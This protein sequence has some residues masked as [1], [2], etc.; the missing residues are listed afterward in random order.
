MKKEVLMCLA[1]ATVAAV[2]AEVRTAGP[3]EQTAIS[4][5]EGQSVTETGPI[6]HDSLASGFAK[7]GTGDYTLPLGTVVQTTPLELSVH[8]GKVKLVDNGTAATVTA[9]D[10]MQ[11][12]VMWL[13]ANDLANGSVETWLDHREATSDQNKYLCVRQTAA[14]NQPTAGTDETGKKW[15]N[16]D[17]YG[18][19]KF[20]SFYNTA[21]T[22]TSK[23]ETMHAFSV[24]KFVASYG[25]LWG[26]NSTYDVTFHGSG[27][28]GGNYWNATE[29]SAAVVEGRTFVNGR[30]I[31]GGNEK[32]VAGVQLIEWAAG[33]RPAQILNFFNDRSIQG[34]QGGGYVGEAVFF[35]KS[36]SESERQQVE[37]YLMQKWM[38]P[39]CPSVVNVRTAEGSAVELG[40]GADAVRVTGVGTVTKSSDGTLH[41]ADAIQGTSAVSWNLAA[42]NLELEQGTTRLALQSGAALASSKDAYGVTTLA[43]EVGVAAGSASVTGGSGSFRLETLPG[44]VS[45]V[46]LT[47]GSLTLGALEDPSDGSEAPKTSAAVLATMSNPGFESLTKINGQTSTDFSDG[48]WT[49]KKANGN[50]AWFFMKQGEGYWSAYTP[51]TPV[52]EG[53][54]CVGFNF[55][56]QTI[57]ETATAATQVEFPQDGDY[58]LSFR[59]VSRPPA[60]G[61]YSNFETYAWSQIEMTLTDVNQDV[62]DLCRF[63]SEGAYLKTSYRSD[64]YLIRGIKAGTYTFTVK[65]THKRTGEKLTLLDDFKFQLV[66]PVTAE[67]VFQVPN[68][69]FERHDYPTLN[70]FD[71]SVTAE[72]WTFTN[73]ELEAG[74]MAA[75]GPLRNGIYTSNGQTTSYAQYMESVWFVS[76]GS[77]YGQC[78]LAFFGKDGKAASAAFVPPAGKWRLR[79]RAACLRSKAPNWN[80]TVVNAAGRVSAKVSVNGGTPVDLG[81]LDISHNDFLVCT[82]PMSFACSGSEPVNIELTQLTDN[83][84]ARL[85]DLELVRDDELITNGNFGTGVGSKTGWTTDS[86]TQMPNFTTDGNYYYGKTV[87]DGPALIITKQGSAE[88]EIEFSE[89]GVYRL[90]FWA[91]GRAHYASPTAEL[92]VMNFAQNRLRFYLKKGGDETEIYRTEK[93]NSTNFVHYTALFPVTTA[94]TYTFGFQGTDT[95]DHSAWIDLVSVKKVSA[96]A[97]PEIPAETDL[98]IRLADGEKLRLDY[99]GSTTV[100]GLKVNGHRLHG[101]VS[102]ATCPDYVTG[103]GSLTATYRPGL[104]LI[105]Q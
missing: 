31:D 84:N 94:G 51:W 4:V 99:T 56:S 61:D 25:F 9:P 1:A 13:D 90:S 98:D 78:Q 58:M 46:V 5:A 37:M 81:Y 48:G 26:V 103:P 29:G 55:N 24:V 14:A 82:F 33:E 59:D 95:E 92:P 57:G 40:D 8:Q 70:A 6:R 66:E 88:Q 30:Q 87:I 76:A 35:D 65:F 18:S 89:T 27:V 34:R 52:P 85:D 43:K 42:G 32:V 68:G 53:S 101:E 28:I 80:G 93:L 96:A 12:A 105:V 102:A 64:R 16:F 50:S 71:T 45:N 41:Y 3:F 44:G 39:V 49:F 54:R 63:L 21:R 15:V 91:R 22:G 11:K 73:P 17:V 77:R 75:V 79:C 104:I 2:N 23:I 7:D 67:T 72:G 47:C 69:D 100:H 20:G 38:D 97:A 36:I 86:W 10:C 83:G 74:K 60:W 62:K 19:G